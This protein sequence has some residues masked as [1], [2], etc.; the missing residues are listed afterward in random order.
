MLCV[1]LRTSQCITALRCLCRLGR[2]PLRWGQTG[3][4]ALGPAE[5]DSRAPGTACEDGTWRRLTGTC[6]TLFPGT[7]IIDP[8]NYLQ[9]GSDDNWVVMTGA[10]GQ[11]SIRA[12]EAIP[13]VMFADSEN[14]RQ[15][16]KR[17][18]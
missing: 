12:K 11:V 15:G 4:S 13:E 8:F 16:R 5:L 1:P 3:S 9:V 18:L 17:P 7:R 2:L 10:A 14:Q 6:K